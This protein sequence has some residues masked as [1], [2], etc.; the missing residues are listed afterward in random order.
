MTAPR[1]IDDVVELLGT[2]ELTG[3]THYEVFGRRHGPSAN[4]EPGIQPPQVMVRRSR[5]EIETRMRMVVD[6]ETA[7]LA[8]DISATYTISEPSE[9]SEDVVT[10]FLERVGLMAVYPYV[11]EAIHTSASRLAV[12]APV[13]GLMRAGSVRIVQDEP[14]LESENPATSDS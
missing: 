10:E 7:T 11:R 5:T 6:T 3:I 9:I 4:V 13:L 2:V 1:E 8:A 12:D 14:A